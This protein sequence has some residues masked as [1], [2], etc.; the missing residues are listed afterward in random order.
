MTFNY[1]KISEYYNFDYWNTQG[2]KS[3]YVDM[4][5]SLG[6]DWHNGACGWFDSII[7]VSGKTLFDAG[8]GLGH[9]MLAFEKLGAFVSGCDVSDYSRKICVPHF[10]DRFYYTSLEELSCVPINF[11]DIVFTS[12]TF[13]HLSP[14]VITQVLI[15]LTN[16]LKPGGLIY[17]EVDTKPNSERDFPE[18]SHIF[19]Q[20]WD[21][22][23][24]IFGKVSFPCWPDYTLTHDLRES[25]A[26]PGFPLTDWNFM[27]FRK[28][29]T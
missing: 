3:G 12:A 4:I 1:K 10:G 24:K 7:P 5:G 6:G 16:I 2:K 13:E 25:K 26:F 21:S 15:N 9:F 19:T 18:D 11:Y 22:W 29:L 20:P 17:I 23:L 28:P 8:C 14:D 27:V